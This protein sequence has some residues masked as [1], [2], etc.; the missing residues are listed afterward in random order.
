MKTNVTMTT[1]T[2]KVNTTEPTK[3]TKTTTTMPTISNTT[4]TSTSNTSATKSTTGTTGGLINNILT[5]PKK[6]EKPK[7]VLNVPPKNINEQINSFNDTLNK[8]I[9][10]PKLDACFDA[11]IRKPQKELKEYLYSILIGYG[12][13]PVY[14]DGYIYAKGEI[15]V[16]LVAHMDTVHTHSVTEICISD[17]GCISSPE[18]I[19]GDDRCGIYSIIQTIAYGR[20][21][22]IL[23]AEDEEIGCIGSEKFCADVNLDIIDKKDIDLKFIIEIDRRGSN[24]CVFYDCDNRDFVTYIEKFGFKEAYGSCSDISYIAPALGV[25]ATNLS[26]AYYNPHQLTEYID[27]EELNNIIYRIGL[28]LDDVIDNP[29]MKPFKY[30]ESKYAGSYWKGYNYGKY[31]KGYNGCYSDYG[32]D[33]DYDY[34]YNYKYGLGFSTEEEKDNKKS[35]YEWNSEDFFGTELS[36]I[37]NDAYIYNEMTYETFDNDYLGE[38]YVDEYGD[39]YEFC[40]EVKIGDIN[41]AAKIFTGLDKEEK[42]KVFIST[43][44]V[45]YDKV[46]FEPVAF[47]EAR[48]IVGYAII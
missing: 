39:V 18:G 5:A 19:G 45:A 29:E 2:T 24:D 26:S 40:E 17:Y 7:E 15:P 22:Y 21:P 34:E 28:I 46:T 27:L 35:S 44:Y 1:N 4:K 38:Y 31:N 47:D 25:A 32:Y 37:E 30:I 42:I 10:F 36:K 41:D 33:D 48:S 23:F 14:N 3:D 12:Y 11:I 6:E 20:K 13:K 8:K 9:E 16:M 43:T